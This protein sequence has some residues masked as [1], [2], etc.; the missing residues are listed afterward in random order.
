MRGWSGS[1]G[2]YCAGPADVELDSGRDEFVDDVAGVGHRPGEP[3]Q[4]GDHQGVPGAARGKG[5][6]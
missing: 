4:L 5:L 6:P 2:S 3:I 1:V